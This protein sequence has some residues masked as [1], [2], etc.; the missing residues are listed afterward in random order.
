MNK[1]YFLII[2]I[3]SQFNTSF[4]C[5]CEVQSIKKEYIVSDLVIMAHVVKIFEIDTSSFKIKISIK[6]LFKGDS[7]NELTVFSDFWTDCAININEGENWLIFAVENDGDYGFGYCSYSKKID[8]INDHIL[9]EELQI[10]RIPELITDY[11]PFDITELDSV[12]KLNPNNST[13]LYL[14]DYMGDNKTLLVRLEISYLGEIIS[15]TIIRGDDD[16]LNKI[17]LE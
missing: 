1:Y 16:Y 3:L 17:V 8:K 13:F 9:P 14:S 6:E 5:E 7:I 15:K 12:P 4:A 2:L 11:Y 10:I